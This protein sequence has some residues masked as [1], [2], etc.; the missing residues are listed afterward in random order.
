VFFVYKFISDRGVGVSIIEKKRFFGGGGIG[1][2]E[3]QFG[4]REQ[5][6][7]VV[8]RKRGEMQ[9]GYRIGSTN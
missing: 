8:Q 5:S 9:T 4:R 7:P 2:V 1:V 6:A 3:N